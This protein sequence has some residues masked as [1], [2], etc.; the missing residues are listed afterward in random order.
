MKRGVVLSGGGTK[1]AYELGVWEALRELSVD[2]QIVTGTSIG[3]INGAIMAS[4]DYDICETMWHE[5][6]MGDLMSEE[7]DM[8]ETVK[9]FFTDG[10]SVSDYM[11][12][13]LIAGAVDNSPFPEFIEKNIDE[14]RL[15]ASGCDYGLVTVRIRDRKPFCLSKKDIPEGLLKEYIIASSSV[16]PVF[17]MKLI[18]QDYFIDG[19]YYDNLPIDLA[20]SMGATEL[21]VVDLHM[22]PQHP[23]YAGRPYVTYITPSEDLGGILSFNNDVIEKNIRMGYRDTM[24]AFG[25]YKGYVYCF[26]PESLKGC[27][28]AIESFNVGCAREEATINQNTK[29]RIKR[30]GEIYRMFSILEK[31]ARGKEVGKEGYFLRGAEIAAEIFG[32]SRETIWDM[33]DMIKEVHEAAGQGEAYPDAA[34]FLSDSRHIKRQMKRIKKE[35]DSKY[36]TGCLYYAGRQRDIDYARML[37]ILSYFPEE[38]AAALFLLATD[39]TYMIK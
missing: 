8:S 18:G 33:E 7:R 26:K 10:G 21:I 3:S 38:L 27:K 30:A 11:S 16:Y 4:G 5:M 23:N 34:T 37:S 13:R 15:R 20:I 14:K 2:F 24:R 31:Y 9:R 36:V 29:N 12:A 1:G 17:P 25:R 32:L 35:H 22:E 39:R 19:M 28:E 6:S